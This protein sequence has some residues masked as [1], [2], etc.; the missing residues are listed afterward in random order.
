MHTRCL[1]SIHPDKILLQVFEETNPD[2]ITVASLRNCI[3][4]IVTHREKLANFSMP[5]A[6]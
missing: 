1:Q 6:N 2:E 5:T 4:N 3:K